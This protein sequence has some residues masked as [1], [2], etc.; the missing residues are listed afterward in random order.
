MS[1]VTITGGTHKG[2]TGIL[3]SHTPHF[4]KVNLGDHVVRCKKAF[5][6]VIEEPVQEDPVQ[7][8]QMIQEKMIQ[9]Q[10]RILKDI[11][12]KKK[13][14]ALNAQISQMISVQ[15]QEYEEG[16]KK[17]LEKSEKE[18]QEIKEKPVFEEVSVEEM[19]RVRLMRFM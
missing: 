16:L 2:K 9:E 1:H 15:N 8:E 19:R 11:L 5:A 13:K 14:Q 3:V 4:T 12:E 7:E 6:Q 17:D 10:E 18:A